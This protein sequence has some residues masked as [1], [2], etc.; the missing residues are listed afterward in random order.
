[1]YFNTVFLKYVLATWDSYIN[2]IPVLNKTSLHEKK[3]YNK[4]RS[5]SISFRNLVRTH[6]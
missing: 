4:V 5:T 3:E 6:P 1:M 2:F